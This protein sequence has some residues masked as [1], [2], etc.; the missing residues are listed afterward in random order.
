MTIK[1]RPAPNT[2]AP[3]REINWTLMS[4]ENL[5]F[6]LKLL[7]LHQ[8]PYEIDAANEFERRTN[9]KLTRIPT[10]RQSGYSKNP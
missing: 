1:L 4:D 3:R 10:S 5:I 2:S 7:S 9:L 6:A 8:S